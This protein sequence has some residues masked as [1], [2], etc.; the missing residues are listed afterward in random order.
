MG[1]LVPLL[2]IN[3]I[4]PLIEAGAEEFYAGFHD[5]AWKEK[6]KEKWDLNR[7]SE[8]GKKANPMSLAQL[9]EAAKLISNYEKKLYVTFNSPVYSDQALLTIKKYFVQLKEAGAT[10]VI[11]SCDKLIPLAKEVN[12]KVTMSTIA[13]IYNEDIAHYYSKLGCDRL[14]LPRDLTLKEILAIRKAVPNIELEVFILRNPC[15]FSDS[16]CLAS[17]SPE[18]LCGYLRNIYCEMILF[19]FLKSQKNEEREYNHDLFSHYLLRNG[20][21]MCALYQFEKNGIDSYKIVGRAD[22]QE[23]I[24]E[25]LKI[26][27]ENLRLARQVKSETE[28]LK[29]MHSPA[30]AHIDCS[31]GLHCYYPEIKFGEV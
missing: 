26:L 25:D 2:N 20:C 21:G 23:E 31:R 24:L 9:L 4:K 27:K 7:M 8:F 11:V 14:I 30:N 6:F 3:W 13:G 17:H 5:S 18:G 10:G 12:L 29:K 16:H 15:I 22:K 1:I 19:P 28:Y